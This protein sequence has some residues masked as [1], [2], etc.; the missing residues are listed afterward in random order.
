MAE[1]IH[2]AVPDGSCGG[3][4]VES[5][6][7]SEEDAKKTQLRTAIKGFDEY[8]SPGTYKRLMRGEVVVMSNTPMEVRTNREFIRRAKGNVLIN[9]LGLG[10]VLTAILRKPEVESVTVI[11]ASSEVIELV[12]P[13][14]RGDPRVSIVH[15]NAFDYQPAKGKCFDAVW[16]DIWD[17]ICA[18]NLPEMHKLHRRYARRADW[19]SSWR[20]SQCEM[21]RS[22]YYRRQTNVINL[23]STVSCGSK[24]STAITM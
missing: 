21:L 10:M 24:K 15:A 17:Y 13:T 14:F 20:R 19:Q 11:E 22:R 6:T 5:F 4:R 1:H 16:H 23:H 7:V 3:W 9:G 8:V 12:A 18:N 2:V